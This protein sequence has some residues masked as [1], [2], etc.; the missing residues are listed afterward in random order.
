MACPNFTPADFVKWNTTASCF[1]I[2]RKLIGQVPIKEVRVLLVKAIGEERVCAVQAL[3]DGKY[4]IEFA[5][6]SI[7]SYYDINGLDFRGINIVPTPAYEQLVQVFI[8]RAPLPMPAKYFI[9]SLTPYGRVVS[10]QDLRVG[11]YKNIHS[12]T[13][14]VSMV[15]M[16]VLKPIPAVLQI[17][18]FAC[19]VRYRGQP[20]FCFGCKAFGHTTNKCQPGKPVTRAKGKGATDPL[21]SDDPHR[22]QPTSFA[23]AAAASPVNVGATTFADYHSPSDTPRSDVLP[24][25]MDVDTGSVVALAAPPAALQVDAPV[26]EVSAGVAEMMDSSIVPPSTTPRVDSTVDAS[27]LAASTVDSDVM[28][29]S[30]ASSVQSR[31]SSTDRLVVEISLS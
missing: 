24:V 14:M 19:S 27:V 16:S 3:P 18:N 15:S 13:R 10:V 17:A 29:A 31:T 23:Q 25:I 1:R 20:P 12:G 28:D 4:R 26:S 2:P 6:P 30:V 9:S 22:S 7:K 21:A 11:G 8:D 5:S